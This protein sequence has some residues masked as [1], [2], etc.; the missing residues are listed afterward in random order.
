MKIQHD[1][2]P[3][4]LQVMPKFKEAFVERYSALTD[5]D[6]FER[7]NLAYL[8]RALRVNTLK[9]SIEE[10]KRRLDEKGWDLEQVPWCKEGFW[11]NHKE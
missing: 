5:W 7:Y 2:H 3:I 6:E 4:K 8:N 11:V 10:L 1:L 9:I